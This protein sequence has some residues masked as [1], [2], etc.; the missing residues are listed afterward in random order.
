VKILVADDDRLILAMLRD[1]L[2][3]LGHTVVEASN[4]VEAVELAR[5][6]QPDL[7]IVDFLMPRLNGIDA[8][9]EIRAA[10][11]RVPG[12]LLSAIS[13]HTVRAL[14]GADAPDAVLQKPFTRKTVARALERV[15]PAR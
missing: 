5:R 8:L 6:E 11:P 9:R 3:E 4:G 15:A 1:L 2:E 12:V 10:G 14:P 13:D 7:A